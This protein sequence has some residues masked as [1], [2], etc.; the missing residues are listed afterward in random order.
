M[1]PY[2]MDGLHM[3]SILFACWGLLVLPRS[4]NNVT[5]DKDMILQH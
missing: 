3:Q 1:T 5:L 4:D 2:T